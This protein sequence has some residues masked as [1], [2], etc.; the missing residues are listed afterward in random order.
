MLKL[1]QEALAAELGRP[2]ELVVVPR[3]REEFV[4]EKGSADLR[5]LTSPDWIPASHLGLYEWP[6]PFMA[7]REFIIANHPHPLTNL[8][9][10]PQ[11]ALIGTVGGYHYPKLEVAFASKRLRRDDATH[12]SSALSKHLAGRVDFTV[13]RDIDVLYQRQRDAGQAARLHITGVEITRT[14][15]YCARIQ[16]GR[17]TLTELTRAQDRLMKQGRLEQIVESVI[18]TKF[19][20][21]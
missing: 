6:R 8:E 2:A 7:I 15:V 14:S 21:P 11:G 18:G 5:C 16:H 1:W 19:A 3:R 12:E 13:M 17:I 4:T 9:D 20:Q 10:L